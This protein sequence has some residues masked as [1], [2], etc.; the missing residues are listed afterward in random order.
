MSILNGRK[1]LTPKQNKFV[2][3]IVKGMNPSE[4]YKDA[5][6]PP[7]FKD[8]TLKC[9]AWKTMQIPHISQTIEERKAENQKEI[10]YTVQDSFNKFNEIQ[11]KALENEDFSVVAKIEELKGKLLGFYTEKKNVEVKGQQTI[12]VDEKLDE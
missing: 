1:K 2:D 8:N 12:F 5:Y 6:N 9:E 7:N 10:N 11:K 3:N 4:A